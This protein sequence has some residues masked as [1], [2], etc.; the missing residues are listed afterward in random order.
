L[1]CHSIY[2]KNPSQNRKKQK[3][4]VSVKY[5]KESIRDVSLTELSFLHGGIS[6]TVWRGYWREKV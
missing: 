4:A 3:K 5:M 1:G 6:S 2:G